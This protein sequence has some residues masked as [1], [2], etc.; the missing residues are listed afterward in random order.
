VFC[1]DPP[2]ATTC[3]SAASK[4]FKVPVV[5]LPDKRTCNSPT[6][7]HGLARASRHLR[8]TVPFINAIGDPAIPGG[9]ALLWVKHSRLRPMRQSRTFHHRSRN[10][11]DVP[12]TR[13]AIGPRLNPTNT[14]TCDRLRWKQFG[15]GKSCEIQTRITNRTATNQ[16]F[17]V[18]WQQSAC[19]PKSAFVSTSAAT[20]QYC[21][22]DRFGSLPRGLAV[23][24]CDT[25]QRHASMLCNS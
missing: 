3:P 7:K 17:R 20:R 12:E 8:L 1:C 14:R 22:Q 10:R 9:T 21:C 2:G 5:A 25:I 6:A 16:Q 15:R 24:P 4:T 19:N 18:G 11:F 13:S 23:L